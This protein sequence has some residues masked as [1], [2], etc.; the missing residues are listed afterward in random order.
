MK[1][2]LIAAAVIA[3]IAGVASEVFANGGN[4]TSW[5][6]GPPPGGGGV[7]CGNHVVGPWICVATTGLCTPCDDPG[8]CTQYCKAPPPGQPGMMYRC[9]SP[10]VTGGW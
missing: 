8:E 3:L 7:P 1:G 4:P 9:K 6:P 2:R 10:M 5:V